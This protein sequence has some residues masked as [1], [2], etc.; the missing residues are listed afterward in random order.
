[1]V[2]DQHAQLVS[3]G[4]VHAGAWCEDAIRQFTRAR[5]SA[6]AEK[7]LRIHHGL[8][9]SVQRGGW[10]QTRRYPDPKQHFFGGSSHDKLPELAHQKAL[11]KSLGV[12]DQSCPVRRLSQKT[13]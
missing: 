9:E 6:S 3:G 13:V 12:K 5:A 7:Q 1:V 4:F 10:K 11:E 8:N 2:V